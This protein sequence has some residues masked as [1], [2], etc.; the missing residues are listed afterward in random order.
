MKKLFLATLTFF[1]AMVGFAQTH[2]IKLVLTD[3]STGEGIPFA[4]VSITPEGSS[5]A[6]K[7]VLTDDQ[8]NAKIDKVAKGSYTLKGEL[9]GYKA[10]S[11]AV[12]VE[13]K[14]LD[15]GQVKLEPDSQMLDAAS[16]SAVG[17]P[18]TIKKDTIEYNATSFKTTD[19]DMLENL[20]KKLPG[21]EV[22]SDGSVTA[23]G[24]T[25][26]KITIDGKT[27]F[28]DDPSLATKNIPAKIVEKV[29]VV[30]KKSDQAM[31]TGI[32]DGEE[33]TII[34]LSLK[35]GMAKGWFG[36]ILAGGGHD[37][38]TVGFGQDARW[39][40]AAM[41]GNFTDKGQVSVIL[42]ANNTNNR[43]FNDMAGSMMS[44][45]RGGQGGM[46]R[47]GGMWGQNNGILT[48]WMAGVNGA[49]S[50][51]DNDMELGANYLYNGTNT[52]VEERSTKT[53]FGNSGLNRINNSDGFSNTLTQGHRV[54][55]RL[56]HKFSDKTS[57][58]FEPQFNYGMG[59]FNEYSNTSTLTEKEEV[60]DS[61]NKGFTNSYGRNQNWT[62][63][64]WLLF[65]QKIG[66]K[67]G[68]TF[69]ANVRYSFSGNKVYDAYNQS[70]TQ[71]MNGGSWEDTYTNQRYESKSSGAS[72]NS[73][74]VYTEPLA[75]NLF[76]EV[77]Y[78]YN[79]SRNVQHKDT[80]DSFGAQSYYYDVHE[81]SDGTEATFRRLVYNP[82][83]E[84]LNETYSNDIVNSSQTHRAGATLQYQT[85][86]LR[87]QIG[88]SFQPTITDNMTNGETYH[89]VKYNWSPQAM[90]N[91]EINDNTEFRIFYRGRS[92]QPSTSQLMP[93]PDNSNPLSVSFGNPYL[94]PYFNH[95]FRGTFGHTNKKTFFSIRV[96]ADG[97]LVQDGISN[98]K[99]YDAN[100]VQY[101][102]PLNGSV[103]GSGNL[104]CFLNSPIAKSNFSV[105][106]MCNVSYASSATYVGKD[107][108]SDFLTTRYYDA[109]NAEFN[110]EQFHKDFFEDKTYSL[111]DYFINNRT[112]TLSVMERLKFTY[113]NDFVE[114]S[115][116]ARTR[117]SKPWY[118]M[119]NAS[120][121]MTFANSVQAEMLWTIDKA[122][123]GINMDG[124]YNW[125][126]G[127]TSEQPS[128]C[129]INAE[130][131]KLLF[132]NKFTLA[133]KCYDILNQSKTLTVR[134]TDAYHSEVRNNTLGRYVILSLTYRFGNFGRA[135][136]QMRDR[137]MGGPRGGGPMG[138]GPRG[139]GGRW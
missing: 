31:F 25:I 81:Y 21:V 135:G 22:G 54:G 53:T 32:D 122:G 121:N 100:G 128:E 52:D 59:R 108:K 116:S 131:T 93:V 112:R 63:S 34:D 28:L 43:G 133:L 111:E 20:L 113:R 6:S 80:Y 66:D 96:F 64:G 37:I 71:I 7:Y 82:N 47:G 86:K 134:D 17:N 88:G 132:K 30:E 23:N 9:L 26:S 18:I 40:G 136:Q 84:T 97:S 19:N 50:L 76:L 38:Q 36:N 15:L 13:D 65:R 61:T 35:K 74:I 14:D 130:I 33:E 41:V 24:K 58:I 105:S 69:S 57:I 123:M 5:K 109:A 104:G 27:F 62:A 138:G 67:A 60:R 16:V 139:G 49:W 99:W 11:Q 103:T 102:L 107:E 101:A 85:K 46:G 55:V 119:E 126:N 124:S 79:W 3:M 45:M 10:A 29:K 92:S 90:I 129:I 115:L 106:N 127:Y 44:A 110:Y 89:S 118:T 87:A 91:Y 2:S 95:N 78:G 39:Q 56:E 70:L 98:A 137:G 83:G 42:N 117:F 125:Y 4:T 75:K 72:I 1:F 8:G 120:S 12:T 94:T 48:S 73:R 114:A 77:Y 51:L 68:R